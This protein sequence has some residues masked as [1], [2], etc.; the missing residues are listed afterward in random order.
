MKM[1]KEVKIFKGFPAEHINQYLPGG[2][3]RG[4]KSNVFKTFL[5][6]HIKFFPGSIKRRK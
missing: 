1:R 2:L 3:K 5:A 4:K 6:E